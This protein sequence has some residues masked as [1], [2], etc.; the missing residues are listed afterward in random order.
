MMKYLPIGAQTFEGLIRGDY[1]YVDKTAYVYAMIQP[2]MNDL[3]AAGPK[4]FFSRPRRFGKSLTVTTLEALFLGK[5]ELFKGLWIDQHTAYTFPVYPVIRLDMSALS[6]E[7]SEL[8][9]SLQRAV[10][11]RALSYGISLDLLPPHEMFETL[12][13]KL[14]KNTPVVVLID[15]YDAPLVR[16]VSE[17]EKARQNRDIL[18]DFYG[19]LKSQDENLRFVFLT[20]VT[21]FSKV[22]VFSGLNHLNDISQ[23]ESYSALCGYTQEELEI[24]FSEHIKVMAAH[25]KQSF[26]ETI[27][28]L[29]YWYNGYRMSKAAIKVY[30]PFSTLNALDK[31][32]FVFKWFESGTPRFLIE[33]IRDQDFDIA[34]AETL[35]LIEKG[36]EATDIDR[37]SL[38]SMLVQTGYLTI[39]NYDPETMLYAIHYPNYEVKNG[40]LTYL[41]E[42]FSGIDQGLSGSMLVKMV[43][44]LKASDLDVFFEQLNLFFAKI[45]YDLH[46]QYERY[47]QSLFHAIFTLLSMKIQSE[48]HTYKGRIDTII[49][50]QDSF[51]IFEFKLDR[52][53]GTEAEQTQ[54]AQ[55]ALEQIEA[56]GYA[57]AYQ[58]KGKPIYLMGVAFDWKER[59]VGKALKKRLD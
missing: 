46:L 13:K 1:V 42:Y 40:F 5:Q 12:I 43:N 50:T 55:A 35:E 19:I 4:Y 51:W 39:R 47:Y 49:E 23:D 31:K 14:G 44:A 17:P 3:L 16:Y 28:K 7:P 59:Q 22:S 58:D 2:G 57:K 21:K 36:F 9:A 38:P 10:F 56:K 24:N 20:G 34:E 18:R 45:P 53:A 33:W 8:K 11:D 6:H 26:S 25:Q 29:K 32:D 54:I 15:E 37:L 41:A 52:N 27:E 30:N 48:V